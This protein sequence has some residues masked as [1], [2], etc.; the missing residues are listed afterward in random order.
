MKKSKR[1]LFLMLALLLTTPLMACAHKGGHSIHHGPRGHHI[2]SHHRHHHMMPPV[3]HIYHPP[4]RT[5]YSH[6]PY[7]YPYYSGISID[8]GRHL[9][10]HPHGFLGTGFHISI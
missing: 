5:Y 9:P 6:Y 8:F 3:R 4:I 2:H 7:Y 10:M 1:I